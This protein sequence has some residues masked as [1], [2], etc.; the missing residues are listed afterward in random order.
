[1]K[2]AVLREDPAQEPRVAATPETV[3]KLIAAGATVA[4]ENGA[5]AASG[6]AD[7]KYR[8]VGA[9]IAGSAQ[10]ALR[11][12]DLVLKVRRPDNL[13]GYRRGS[14]VLRYRRLPTRRKPCRRQTAARRVARH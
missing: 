9:E 7:Q 11:D 10:D 8:D 1:M 2:V 12:V 3:K 6:L 14:A 5:G 13:D 4:V